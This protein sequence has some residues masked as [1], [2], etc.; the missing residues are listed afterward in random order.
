MGIVIAS[1]NNKG[2]CGKTTNTLGLAGGLIKRGFRVLTIDLDGQQDTTIAL[3]MKGKGPTI[4]DVLMNG[5][6]IRDCIVGTSAG[7]LV[8]SAGALDALPEIWKRDR[9]EYALREALEPI[10]AEYDFI[11][12]DMPPATGIISINA[13]AAADRLLIA[14]RPEG[15]DME[16]IGQFIR[17]VE[18][19]KTRCN[20]DLIIQGIIIT[21]YMSN[22]TIHKDMYEN[23]GAIAKALGTKLYNPIR[24]CTKIKEAQA[25]HENL[26]KYSPKCNAVKDYEQVIKDFLRDIERGDR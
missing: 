10:K 9:R 22:L 20:K 6:D 19:V 15:F 14:A 2:G 17:N 5:E 7:D 4:Y 16:G 11:I 13:L 23:A 12:L 1:G 25:V 26:Y 24:Q 18:T 3:G 21:Q 8:P